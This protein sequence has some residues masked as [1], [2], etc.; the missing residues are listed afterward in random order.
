MLGSTRSLSA[1]IVVQQ[2][3]VGVFSVN[4]VVNV[5]D[6]GS[7]FVGSVSSAR[8]GRNSPGF[9]LLP[10]HGIGTS[11]DHAAVQTSVWIHDLREEDERILALARAKSTEGR[12]A[13]RNVPAA[14]RPIRQLAEKNFARLQASAVPRR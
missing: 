5:P 9:S 3:V 7:A 6:G 8:D 2:P 14:S 1:Q 13:D 11:R 4:T 10:N 12:I